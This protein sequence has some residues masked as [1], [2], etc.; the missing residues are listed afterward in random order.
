VKPASAFAAAYGPR[1]LALNVWNARWNYRRM[2]AEERLCSHESRSGELMGAD[3]AIAAAR[4]ICI[5]APNWVGDVVMATPAFRAVRTRCPQARITLVVRSGVAAVLKG[6]PWFDEWLVYRE[7]PPF[8][9]ARPVEFLRCIR[10]LRSIHA[11]LGIVLPNSFSSALMFAMAGVKRRVGYVR[12]CR[13]LL[14]TDALQRPS[15]PNGSFRPIYMGDYYLALCR[16]AGIEADGKH[17]ELYFSHDDMAAAKAILLRANI[18]L[19]SPLF[20]LH[21]HAAYGPSKLWR[22][23]RFA[24]LA[25]MLTGEFGGQAACIGA[26]SASAAVARINAASKRGVKD[27]TNC[28]LD[29]HLLKCAVKLARLLVTTDSGP[30]HYG[31]ALGVPTVCLMGA[32]NPDYTNSGLPHDHIVRVDVECG[33]CQKKTC[34]RD[35]RCMELITTEMVFDACRQALRHGGAAR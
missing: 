17:T 10:A 30:R 33:P 5:R 28:G 3:N 26:P 31:I 8:S 22:E 32:T 21:P 2:S 24:A 13:R 20:L 14:L 11:D 1:K 19:T 34:R 25:D 6:A 9:P 16:K 4:S 18:D 27:L 12:D 29:L 23:D 15:H 35:H 7:R